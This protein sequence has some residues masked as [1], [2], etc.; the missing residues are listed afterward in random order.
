[1]IEQTQFLFQFTS[2]RDENE[3]HHELKGGSIREV[4]QVKT[5]QPQS[6]QLKKSFFKYHKEVQDEIWATVIE[7]CEL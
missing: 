5:L 3:K 6:Q 4:L 7:D 2:I 1:M